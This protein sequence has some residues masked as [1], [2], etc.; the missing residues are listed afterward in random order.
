[1]FERRKEELL[2]WLQ[3]TRDLYFCSKREKK[4]NKR[5]R[6]VHLMMEKTTTD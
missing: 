2:R 1:V 6:A 3:T 5:K 4:V